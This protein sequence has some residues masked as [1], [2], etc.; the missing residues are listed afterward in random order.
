MELKDWISVFV[1]IWSSVLATVSLIHTIKKD[2]KKSNQK[3][4]PRKHLKR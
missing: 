1:T 3:A 2:S 4:A